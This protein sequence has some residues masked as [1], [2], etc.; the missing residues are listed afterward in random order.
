ML[1]TSD[2]CIQLLVLWAVSFLVPHL[3]CVAFIAVFVIILLSVVRPQCIPIFHDG[4]VIDDVVNGDIISA[5]L[6]CDQSIANNDII[7]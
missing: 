4:I 1:L 6:Y 2:V 5:I 7:Y 3:P